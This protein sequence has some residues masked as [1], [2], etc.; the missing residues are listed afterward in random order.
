M[1]ITGIQAKNVEMTDAI[2]TY[3]EE[4]V[5]TLSKFTERYSPCDLAIELILNTKHHNK[6]EIYTAHLNMSI[7]GELLRA[8]CTAED[9]YKA[10]DE[11]KDE[12]KRQLIDRK[13]R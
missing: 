11:A 10:I 7:P 13:E 8:E 9:L 1:R 4:K 12:L 3:V 2:K 6:G 5:M